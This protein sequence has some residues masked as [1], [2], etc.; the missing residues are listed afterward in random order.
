MKPIRRRSF[1]T[2][3]LT[4][5]LLW[6]SGHPVAAQVRSE[7]L[8]L[9]ARDRIVF[10][11]DSI[12]HGGHYLAS[13]QNALW[14]L[15]PEKNLSFFNAGV[16]GDVA[17]HAL[18]RLDAEV[19]AQKPNVVTILLGMND[20]GY[21]AFNEELLAN[22]RR[23][24]TAIVKRLREET[25]AKLV[26]LSPTYFDQQQVPDG[27]AD[28][29]DYNGTLIRYGDVCR[30]LAEE[31]KCRFVDLN[32][33]LL[34]ATERLRIRDADA[35]LVP[36]AVHPAEAGGMVMAHAMLTG[37][38]GPP[39]KRALKLQASGKSASSG[40]GEFKLRAISP[41]WDNETCSVIAADLDWADHWN[42]YYLQ[43]SFLGRG[44]W[45]VWLGDAEPVVVEEPHE[46]KL[47]LPA[48]LVERAAQVQTLVDRR[49]RMVWTDIRDEVW[50]IKG[51]GTP[52]SR[53]ERYA[54][55]HPQN[56]KLAWVKIVALNQE[57][58]TLLAQPLVVPYRIERLDD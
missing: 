9:K 18:E 4:L 3:T 13:F 42:P 21:Q 7:P 44:R 19:I 56:L 17:A 39:V 51:D 22:Y 1:L 14:C 50:K 10:L 40:Q 20:A 37:L 2:A 28:H 47:V 38:L 5:G 30:Q 48:S 31:Y 54:K 27:G 29:L 34:Q 8:E 46:S 35:T 26:L 52:A 58:A 16:S 55:I 33:P 32:A 12:T 6:G 11:G 53:K 45:K 49:R 23:D 43:T 41:A 57:I 15:M 24:M 36:D 25:E